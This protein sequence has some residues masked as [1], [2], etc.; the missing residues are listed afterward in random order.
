VQAIATMWIVEG[1]PGALTIM[2]V[3]VLLLGVWLVLWNY[4]DKQGRLPAHT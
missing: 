3:G 2:L 4:C 1:L